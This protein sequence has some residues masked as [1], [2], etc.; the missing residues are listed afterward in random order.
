M[1][2]LGIIIAIFTGDSSDQQ[3][4]PYRVFVLVC[5]GAG[6]RKSRGIFDVMCFD[7]FL[8]KLFGVFVPKEKKPK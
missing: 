1:V 6:G 3:A 4:L 5:Q 7:W 2:Y 8:G